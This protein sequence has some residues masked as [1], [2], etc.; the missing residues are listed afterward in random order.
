MLCTQT[1]TI[2]AAAAAGE[3]AGLLPKDELDM[4]VNDIRPIMKQQMP[5][6]PDT[7]ENL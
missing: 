2:T 4:I 3:V 5:G 6:L 7:W 1:F